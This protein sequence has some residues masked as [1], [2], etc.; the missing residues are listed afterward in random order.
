MPA[1]NPQEHRFQ[2]G[3]RV[4]IVRI[5]SGNLLERYL[6]KSLERIIRSDA[7]KRTGEVWEVVRLRPADAAGN[8]YQV[9]PMGGGPERL[10]HEEQLVPAGAPSG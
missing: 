9:R 6:D 4:R 3:D 8:Q 7:A 5:P 2:V 10:V 1:G